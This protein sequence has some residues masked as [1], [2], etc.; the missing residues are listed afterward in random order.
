M[1]KNI[2]YIGLLVLTGL[3]AVFLIFR[4]VLSHPNGFLFAPSDDAIKSYF[5]FAYYLKYDD[6]IKLDAINYPYGEHLMYDNTHPLYAGILKFMDRNL[7]PLSG[8]A[9]GILNLTMILSLI[10]ALPFIFLILRKY[11]LP[12]WY[13]GIISLIILFLSPQINRIGGHFEMVYAFF[14]PMFWYFLIRLKEGKKPYLWGAL[15][16]ITGLV[17]GFTSAYYAAF[18]T[19]FLLSVWLV[20][21]LYN[22]RNIPGNIGKLTGLFFI[23]IIPVAVVKGFVSITDWA[24]DRPDNPWGF[25][26]FHANVYS[27]FFPSFSPLQFLAGKLLHIRYEWEGRSYVGLP[28]SFYALVILTGLV[29]FISRRKKIQ[30]RWLVPDSKLRFYLAAAFAA[31]LFSMC[32]PFEQ[33]FAFLT[34]LLPPLKQFRALGRFAW[35]FYYVFTVATAWYIYFIFRLLRRKKMPVAGISVLVISLSLWIIDAGVH[36]KKSTARIFNPNILLSRTDEGYDTL[37]KEAGIDTSAYQAILFL[38]LT[39]TSGDK[40]LFSRGMETYGDAIQCSYR[41][42]LPMIESF[43]PRISFTHALSAIQMGADSCIEK[44]R[45]KDMNGKDILLIYHEDKLVLQEKWIADHSETILKTGKSTFAKLPPSFFIR[46]HQEWKNK[47]DSLRITLS[48]DENFACSGSKEAVLCK[49]FDDLQ[50]EFSFTSSGALYR[51][52]GEMEVFN[53]VIHNGEQELVFDLSFWMYIDHR[54]DN[55]P[56]A[57]LTRM[58]D[59]KPDGE[60]RKI[61][62]REIFNVYG[63]WARI[64]CTF[65]AGKGEQFRLSVKGKYITIDDLLVKPLDS[66]VSVLDQTGK[67]LF[68]NFPYQK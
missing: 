65:K 14:L 37:M 62:T 20:E 4:P 6:G 28:A 40:L 50:S 1:R 49:S 60:S 36:V 68:D 2:F 13:A 31:L 39:N 25:F 11:S 7:F 21:I 63:K 16:V 26:I 9:A 46:K 15:L 29:Y 23:A 58:K 43:A 34:D 38:P 47:A 45:L 22:L 33:G 24:D 30:W 56:D 32:I 52:K 55:M 8:Y 66:N 41:T 61:E 12:A 35:I 64:A 18:Y 44:V 42:G 51:R 53:Q 3:I 67:G 59:N 48:G 19:V 54:T 27:V 17:G 57:Y 5:N 10:L